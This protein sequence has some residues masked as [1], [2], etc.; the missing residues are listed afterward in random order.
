MIAFAWGCDSV[1]V[2]HKLGIA[3]VEDFLVTR[4]DVA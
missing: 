2:S 3:I 4:K 1:R